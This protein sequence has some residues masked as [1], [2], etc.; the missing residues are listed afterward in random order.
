MKKKEL[1]EFHGMSNT[2][3][4]TTWNGMRRRCGDEKNPSW[5]SYGGRGIGVCEQW[6]NSFVQFFTDMGRKPS[7]AHSLER[8]DNSKGYFPENCRW[9]TAKE[10][11]RN[12]RSS[13]ILCINGI[14]KTAAEWAEIAGL[15][16]H[17]M[18]SR[19]N[20]LG[21]QGDRLLLPIGG[22]RHTYKGRSG[23]L[24]EIAKFF[25]VDADMVRQRVKKLGWGLERAIETPVIFCAGGGSK[26]KHFGFG[27]SLTLRGWSDQ[28]GIGY[29]TLLARLRAGWTIEAAVSAPL[30]SRKAKTP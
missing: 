25:G 19:I 22:E 17:V 6:Q 8:I 3:E 29:Q 10:Q 16:C 2:P 13:R 18:T 27:K 20:K 9:A 15:P 5:P 12:T 1:R 24:A 11:A 14:D 4:Y 21:W 28:C 23:T 26:K 7:P 30:H